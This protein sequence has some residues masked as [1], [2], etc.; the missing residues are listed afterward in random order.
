MELGSDMLLI[1]GLAATRQQAID[2]LQ[3]GIQS[4]R[5][6]AT[7][8]KLIA[9]QGG[10]DKVV[11]DVN[12][13]PQPKMRIEIESLVSGYVQAIDALEVG[14]ASKVLGAGRRKKDGSVDPS[15]GIVLKKKVGDRVEKGEPIAVLFTDG[16][17]KKTEPAKE[18]FLN[19]YT[20][21]KK[22]VQPPRFFY[23]RV[24]KEGV[25]EL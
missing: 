3:A 22:Q 14:L 6:I 13:L 18:K 9:L 10:H 7:L 2:L 24:T 21:G 23:A 25:E 15:V 8:K 17:R 4:K 19:A 11:D 5:S 12:L 20:I 16:D 1:S